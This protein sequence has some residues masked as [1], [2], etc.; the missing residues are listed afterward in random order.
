MA[1]H[2]LAAAIHA[3][4]RTARQ[5]APVSRAAGDHGIVAEAAP[6]VVLASTLLLARSTTRSRRDD[7]QFDA[8]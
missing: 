7:R 2:G 3:A 1:S 4:T 8:G 5:P 6:L